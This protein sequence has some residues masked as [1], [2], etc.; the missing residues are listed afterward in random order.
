LSIA[1]IILHFN[2]IEIIKKFKP[3][4]AQLCTVHFTV[5]QVRILL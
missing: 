1:I 3:P 2:L 5:Y 4:S